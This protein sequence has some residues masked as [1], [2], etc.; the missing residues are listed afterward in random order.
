MASGHITKTGG[1]A[2]PRG[3]DGNWLYHPEE[4]D[5][6]GNGRAVR[7]GAE[8]IFENI[9]S[10]GINRHKT[11]LPGKFNIIMPGALADSARSITH[12]VID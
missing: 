8:E 7:G 2:A 6:Y 9:M 10:Q 5:T 12:P 11:F 1:C 4:Y 3:Y